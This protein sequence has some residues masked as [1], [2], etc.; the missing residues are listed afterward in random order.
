MGL[1]NQLSSN[2]IEYGFTRTGGQAWR[3]MVSPLRFDLDCEVCVRGWLIT[4]VSIF[5]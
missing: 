4:F 3:E 2:E 5:F 1:L